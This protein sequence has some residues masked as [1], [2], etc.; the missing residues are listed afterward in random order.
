M[1]KAQLRTELQATG[2]GNTAANVTSQN[3]W[4]RAAYVWVWNYAR[5]AFK[6][7][8]MTNLTVVA[9]DATPAMPS[10]FGS[11]RQILNEDGDPLVEMTPEEFDR[12]FQAGAIDGETGKPYAFKVVNRVVTLG[13]VPDA[14][15][16]FKWSYERRVSHLETDGSTV[17]GGFMD[18]DDDLPLWPDDHHSVLVFHAAMIGH[19][20]NRNDVAAMHKALRDEAILAMHADL[21]GERAPSQWPAYR[22]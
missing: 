13:P 10:D 5:W 4:L 11:V 1:T 7:V 8:D 12:R 3:E 18:E 9:G 20:G 19:G 22:P 16:A 2:F 14:S 6:Q 21:V 17:T 15:A